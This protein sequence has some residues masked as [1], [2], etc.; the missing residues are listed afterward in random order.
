MKTVPIMNEGGGYVG[1]LITLTLYIISKITVS[2]LASMATILSGCIVVF[3]NLP[4]AVVVFNKHIKPVFK[5][6]I[7]SK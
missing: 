7:K 6:K 4:K 3:V 1:G 5:K 2:D